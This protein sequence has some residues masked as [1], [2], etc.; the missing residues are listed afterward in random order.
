[1]LTYM[2]HNEVVIGLITITAGEK[3]GTKNEA[4]RVKFFEDQLIKM[5]LRIIV[6]H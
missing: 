4:Q 6:Y 5:L 1:M 2:E 3:D